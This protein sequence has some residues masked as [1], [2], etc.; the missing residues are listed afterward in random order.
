[1]LRIV[2]L[3]R[4]IIMHVTGIRCPQSHYARAPNSSLSPD[5]AQA[6]YAESSRHIFETALRAVMTSWSASIL[7]HEIACI[8]AGDTPFVDFRADI[9]RRGDVECTLKVYQSRDYTTIGLYNAPI[10][11]GHGRVSRF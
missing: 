3:L 4:F 8:D 11:A 6:T 7:P 5:D 10:T 9:D 2:C 1:M